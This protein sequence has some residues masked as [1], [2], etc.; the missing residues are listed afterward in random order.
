MLLLM[1]MSLLCSECGYVWL[2]FMLIIWLIR[3]GCD[4]SG[5]GKFMIW[6]FLVWFVSLFGFLCDGFLMRICLIFLIIDWLMCVMFF[7]I[8]V[9][10]CCRCLSFMLC[11]VL[12][13]RFVVGVLGCGL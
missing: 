7:L 8:V 13:V 4:V 11:G 9:C 2:I 5:V 10:R 12:L 3:C 6:L 1:I